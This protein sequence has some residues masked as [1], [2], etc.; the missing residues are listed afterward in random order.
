MYL[1]R[2]IISLAVAHVLWLGHSVIVCH[3]FMAIFTL[4]YAGSSERFCSRGL[5]KTYAIRAQL[6]AISLVWSFISHLS[7]VHRRE[8]ALM[9]LAKDDNTVFHY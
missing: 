3:G 4:G 9:Y 1:L 5:Y 6:L 8:Q 2:R 7:L